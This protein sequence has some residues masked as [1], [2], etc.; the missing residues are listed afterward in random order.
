[1]YPFDYSNNLTGLQ[2]RTISYDT[3]VNLRE[4]PG[5]NSELYEMMRSIMVG[6]ERL[7]K[8]LMMLKN[9]KIQDDRPST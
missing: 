8:E 6:Q 7:E 1:L 9:S 4:E 2:P 3:G 5:K